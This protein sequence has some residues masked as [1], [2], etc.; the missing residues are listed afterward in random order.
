MRHM[1]AVER[2]QEKPVALV[3]VAEDDDDIR[4][5]V[6]RV[7]RRSGHE[8][9]DAADG[10][11]ALEA[12]R[13]HRPRALVTD[14]DMPVMSG[15]E[16]CAALRADPELC[17]LP[18]IFVSGSL[19]PGDTRPA[20]AGA[21]AVVTKPF[22]PRDLTDALEQALAAGHQHSRSPTTPA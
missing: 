9:V 14:L 2:N 6:V 16:L 4:S 19:L 8:V 5:I 20:E 11:A 1:V 18:V 17:D 10:A 7:L 3:V 13:L 12:V 22:R 15:A 21:T